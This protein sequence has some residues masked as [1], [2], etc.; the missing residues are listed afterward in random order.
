MKN[1]HRTVLS[2][3][4]MRE[5]NCALIQGVPTNIPPDV[6]QYWIGNKSNLSARLKGLLVQGG[7][8]FTKEELWQGFNVEVNYETSLLDAIYAGKYDEV[9]EDALRA[10]FNREEK[11]LRQQIQLLTFKKTVDEEE[12]QEEIERLGYRSANTQEL[13]ALGSQ[14]PVLQRFIQITSLGSFVKDG[15]EL[16]EKEFLVLSGIWWAGDDLPMRTLLTRSTGLG[17]FYQGKHERYA[18]AVVNNQ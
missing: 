11:I 2:P 9:S 15:T 13:L 5:L 10:V 12:V 8:N 7:I 17:G 3:A 1:Y 16:L 4:Q 6:A 18:F 14:F